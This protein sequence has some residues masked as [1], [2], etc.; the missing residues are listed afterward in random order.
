MVIVFHFF[1]FP[2]SYMNAQIGNT[3]DRHSCLSRVCV[4]VCVLFFKETNGMDILL[5][6]GQAVGRRFYR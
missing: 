6:P 1:F 3:E 5:Y 4:C 2:D